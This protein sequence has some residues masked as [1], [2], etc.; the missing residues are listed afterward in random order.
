[1]C[2]LACVTK[3]AAVGGGDVCGG[4][5]VVLLVLEVVLLLGMSRARYDQSPVSRQLR[6][7][8]TDIVLTSG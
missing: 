8:D 4:A 2:L 1:M 5:P 6:V 3:P 7:T